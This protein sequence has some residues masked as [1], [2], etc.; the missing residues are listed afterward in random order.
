MLRIAF[1]R[2]SLFEEVACNA[3]AKYLD[4][5]GSGFLPRVAMNASI[6]QVSGGVMVWRRAMSG[7]SGWVISRSRGE[8]VRNCA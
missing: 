6:T 5:S 7:L 2:P 8:L 1:N 4:S 3:S